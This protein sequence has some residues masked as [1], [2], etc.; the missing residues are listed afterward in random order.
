[1]AFKKSIKGD[2]NQQSEVASHNRIVVEGGAAAFLLVAFLLALVTAAL[3]FMVIAYGALLQTLVVIT[4]V[5]AFISLWVIAVVFTRRAVSHARTAVAI[6]ETVRLQAT[7]QAYVLHAGEAY[8]LYM[9]P[10]GKIEAV[11][12]VHID[13]HRQYLPQ[14]AREPDATEIILTDWDQGMSARSIEKHLKPEKV[15]L[16]Q[17]YK[18]L[19]TYRP[20]WNK[21]VT[22]ESDSPES[23]D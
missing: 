17:I 22:V 3:V 14:P 1:M 6:D 11:T 5:G 19:D 12:S 13:E 20:G 9:T 10:E 23:P 21:K 2:S 4:V 7:R 8:A 16:R 15:S 18:V